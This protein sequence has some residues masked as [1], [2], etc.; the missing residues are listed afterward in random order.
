M[1][2][3]EA[4]LLKP[5]NKHE[6]LEMRM[7]NTLEDKVASLRGRCEFEAFLIHEKYLLQKNNCTYFRCSFYENAYP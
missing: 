7:M 1:D 5:K 3:V 2:T 6:V 4:A